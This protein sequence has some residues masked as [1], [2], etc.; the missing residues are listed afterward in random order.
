MI[1]AAALE[2][3]WRTLYSENFQH[4]Q[5]IGKQLKVVNLFVN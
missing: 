1:V 5:V 2:S 4:G 3:V